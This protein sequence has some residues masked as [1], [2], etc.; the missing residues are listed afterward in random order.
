VTVSSSTPLSEIAPAT[1]RVPYAFRQNGSTDELAYNLTVNV[2]QP[3]IAALEFV[4][5]APVVDSQQVQNGRI[6]VV[7]VDGIACDIVAK[8][9]GLAIRCS[10]GPANAARIWPTTCDCDSACKRRFDW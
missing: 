9:V 4:S 10:C 3:V 6:E 5:Q 2:G 8:V 1:A 7:Y